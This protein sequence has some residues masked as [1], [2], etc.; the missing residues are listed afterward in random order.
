MPSFVTMPRRVFAEGDATADHPLYT[1]GELPVASQ[2]LYY[3]FLPPLI[4]NCFYTLHFFHLRFP[5]Y[6]TNSS[7]F[8]AFQVLSTT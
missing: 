6:C 8:I 4:R 1:R 5:G 7:I 2:G 3:P